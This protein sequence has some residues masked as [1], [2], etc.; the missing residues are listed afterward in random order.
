MDIVLWTGLRY[1][2]DFN[3]VYVYKSFISCTVYQSLTYKLYTSYLSNG[4]SKVAES[5]PR[6]GRKFPP[7]SRQKF[8]NIAREVILSDPGNKSGNDPA[9]AAFVVGR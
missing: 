4:N 9:A 2:V 6:K 1:G 5:R 3:F 8:H 7:K